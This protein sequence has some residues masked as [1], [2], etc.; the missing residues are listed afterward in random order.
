MGVLWVD[1]SRVFESCTGLYFLTDAGW[2]GI[3]CWVIGRL[4][5]LEGLWWMIE[6]AGIYPTRGLREMRRDRLF[7]VSSEAACRGMIKRWLAVP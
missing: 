2:A 5:E 4:K 6:I 1:G 3:R 7:A